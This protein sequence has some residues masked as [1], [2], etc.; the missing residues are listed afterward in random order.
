MKEKYKNY[1]PKE[2]EEINEIFLDPTVSCLWKIYNRV[3]D[4]YTSAIRWQDAALLLSIEEFPD[5]RIAFDALDFIRSSL[6]NKEEKKTNIIKNVEA[7]NN[8][9]QNRLKNKFKDC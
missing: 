9:Y 4:P 7:K 8:N 5:V 3:V 6:N 2:T 1:K